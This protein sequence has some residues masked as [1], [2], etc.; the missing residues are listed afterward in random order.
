MC[1]WLY[2]GAVQRPSTFSW[3]QVIT[4]MGDGEGRGGHK[5]IYMALAFVLLLRGSLITNSLRWFAGEDLR[6]EKL[7]RFIRAAASSAL[8]YIQSFCVLIGHLQRAAPAL[9]RL[10]PALALV[11]EGIKQ[12]GTC[13]KVRS[14]IQLYRPPTPSTQAWL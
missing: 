10:K 13:S 4:V 12:V 6:L 11:V 9:I 7:S 3:F 14:C 8:S 2:T 5:C 1:R